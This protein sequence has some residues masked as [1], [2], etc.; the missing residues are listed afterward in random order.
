M[1][2]L[3]LTLL[4]CVT[5]ATK[6]Y[7]QTTDD[8]VPLDPSVRY[9]KLSNGLTYYIRHNDVQPQRADFY[10]AQ[11]VGSILEEDHQSGL[12]HFLEHMAFHNTKNF[13][14]NSLI[15]YLENNGVQFGSNLNASTSVDQTVYN[16][17]NVPVT[18]SSLV[19][20]CLLVLHDWSGFI[21]LDDKTID[22]ERR[23]IQEEWRQ[24]NTA[25]QRLF[26][27]QLPQVYPEGCRYAER[28][29]IGSMNVVANF[30]YQAL[31]DYYHRWYRPDLQAIIVVGDVD[32]DYVEKKLTE[33]WADIPTP[34]NPAKREYLRVPAHKGVKI[35][36][37][38][39]PEA[40]SNS[41]EML[42]NHDRR[43]RENSSNLREMADDFIHSLIAHMINS[44]LQE[45]VHTGRSPFINASTLDGD[46]LLTGSTE[47]WGLG[48]GFTSGSWRPA[49]TGLV[50][51]AKR[52][53]DLGFLA[54]E[55]ER[56]KSVMETSL[57]EGKAGVTNTRNGSYVQNYL[58]HFLQ[59]N[60]CPSPLQRFEHFMAIC[61]TLSLPYVNATARKLFRDDNQ[62]IMLMGIEQ[63]GAPMP[64]HEEVKGAYAEAWTQTVEQYVDSIGTRPLLTEDRLPQ[65]GTIVKEI[66]N[67]ALGYTTWKLSNGA[68]VVLKHTDFAKNSITLR[69]VSPGGT[70]LY[71]DRLAPTYGSINSV[72]GLGGLGSLSAIELTRLLE[73]KNAHVS[74]GVETTKENLYGSCS[75]TFLTTMIQMTHLVFQGAREDMDAFQKW[76]TQVRP[77]MYARDNSA[78]A[79]LQ[80]SINHLLYP[81][82]IRYQGFKAPMLDRVNYR[83]ALEMFAQR[84]SN[85][86]DFTFFIIG[87][88][89]EATLRSLVCQ[90]IATIP[91]T[92]KKEKAKDVIPYLRKGEYVCHFEREMEIPRST[93][94]LTWGG[95]MKYTLYN[96]MCMNI[97]HQVLDMIYMQTLRGE[98]GGTYGA[99]ASYDL[100]LE[101]RDQYMF[102][103]NFQTNAEKL[104][105]M[106]QR[107]KDG[108]RQIA[109]EG[110]T[111]EQMDKVVTFMHKRHNDLLRTNA[112]WMQIMQESTLDKIDN[113]THYDRT[114]D[115]LTRSDIQQC[116]R[117]LLSSPTYIEVVMKGKGKGQ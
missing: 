93:V 7:A 48:A 109:E 82:N 91:G 50:A 38:S 85:A 64:S 117:Q 47:S 13:P 103:V 41:V 97:V 68:T 89:D 45:Y 34:V 84:Y 8:I 40:T 15:G 78:E 46:F 115:A 99:Q 100:T 81:G 101:P 87:N 53:R 11:R 10:I 20:S 73:G 106:L 1:Y 86:S 4:A 92:G 58:G 59:G 94:A 114:L 65:P 96:R 24:R 66:R 32:V 112:Y 60:Y 44:R 36:I 113:Y 31:R 116:A 57:E 21:E 107:A 9:G 5:F 3:I 2:R 72:C 14:D 22:E 17:A 67:E 110:I 23:V 52:V 75:P 16:I 55:F 102:N 6:P 56:A 35:G 49:L 111:E 104:D 30:P 19:D 90:Y 63:A 83:K 37:S 18:R 62:V 88:Y 79:Q 98:E 71:E 39:D 69:A 61:D 43:D 77:T 42:F 105:I 25:D 12:A 74:F 76:K 54:S 27:A 70:S 29:P 51:E 33:M 26:I 28:I 80:D 108:L 95:K